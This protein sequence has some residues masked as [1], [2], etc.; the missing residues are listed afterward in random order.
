MALP[1]EIRSDVVMNDMRL[2][3]VSAGD[4]DGPAFLFLH[5]WPE[6]SRSWAPVMTQASRHAHTIA[7]DLPGIGRSTGNATD[8]SKRQLAD[9]VHRLITTM[10]L[11]D[12][13]LVGQD[14]GGMICYAY[15]RAYR[16][17]A[18]AVIMD[19]VVPGV[20]P[21]DDVLRN[22]QIWHFGLHSVPDLPERLVRG[23]Q[24]E[25]FDFFYD[26]LAADPTTITE[27]ARRAYTRAYATDSALTAGFNWYRTFPTDAEDNRR[28]DGEPVSTPV[29]YLRGEHERGDVGTYARGL[30]AA[31]LTRL[32]HG[33]VLGVGHFAQEEA[34][35]ATWRLLA[36]FAARHPL[37]G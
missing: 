29:L 13:T 27:D 25:Y 5:G 35:E 34:P 32:E 26:A 30:R 15:L 22:P 3:V 33:E 1:N 21:W 19:V 28:H 8:G 17:I 31:G 10:G 11:T 12:V 23:R 14:I 7:V 18:R 16:D 36:D 37:K 6:S 9:I 4:P 24:R 20:D 2:H